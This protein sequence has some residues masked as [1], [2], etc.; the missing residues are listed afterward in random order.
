MLTQSQI[1]AAFVKGNEI[2]DSYWYC[3]GTLIGDE[4][5]R[6]LFGLTIRAFQYEVAARPNVKP[7]FEKI[8]A[9]VKSDQ[10]LKGFIPFAV[11]IGAVL[12][13][14]IGKLLDY[15]WGQYSGAQSAAD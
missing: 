13:W 10:E 3:G 15:L 8:K 14:I 11:I 5:R 1:Q 2:A 6:R 12:S 7:D 9:E 4:G